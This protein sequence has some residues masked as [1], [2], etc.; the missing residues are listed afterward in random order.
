MAGLTVLSETTARRQKP[1]RSTM[2]VKYHTEGHILVV[3]LVGDLSKQ[4]LM[5]SH[6]EASERQKENGIRGILV[7]G[8]LARS[9][10][11]TAERFNLVCSLQEM[12]SL[13]T[14]HAVVYTPGHHDPEEAT[15]AENVATNR[16]VRLKMF[17][18]IGDARVWLEIAD[19]SS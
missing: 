4:D 8:R 5:Q 13:V 18:D 11:S 17:T 6:R 12:Y 7:D 2:S 9:R 15:F 19:E 14:K 3:T 1:E 10:V 16:G